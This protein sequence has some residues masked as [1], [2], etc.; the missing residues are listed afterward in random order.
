MGDYLNKNSYK[1]IKP[2]ARK[3]NHPMQ[4]QNETFKKILNNLEILFPILFQ[5]AAILIHS[6]HAILQTQNCLF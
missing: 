4:G 1:S 5:A 2:F 3:S 6:T